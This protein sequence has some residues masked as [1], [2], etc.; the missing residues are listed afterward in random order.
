MKAS[1][2]T[3]VK[4]SSGAVL[5]SSAP[6]WRTR[7]IGVPFLVVAMYLG[8]Q[9]V[10][11]VGDAVTARDASVIAIPGLLVMLVFFAAFAIPAILLL[12]GR[13]EAVVDGSAREVVV[14]QRYGFYTRERRYPLANFAAVEVMHESDTVG[15][16]NSRQPI[17]L[18][19]FVVRLQTTDAQASERIVRLGYFND[20]RVDDAR[21]L[22]A[23][24][25]PLAGLDLKDRTAGSVARQACAATAQ[26]GKV[27]GWRRVVQ[28]ILEALFTS[29]G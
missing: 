10:A 1:N 4:S 25:A 19:Q 28:F 23:E 20:D 14:R 2:S 24:V 21:R 6:D 7:L 22:A 12:A 9:I 27:T 3:W 5:V 8:Y 18:S 11:S 15:P 13:T 17:H 26:R 29:R 16:S